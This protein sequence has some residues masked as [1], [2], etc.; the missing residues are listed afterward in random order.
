MGQPESANAVG[1]GLEVE[2]LSN[3]LDHQRL[4][5]PDS[6]FID[7]LLAM[8]RLTGKMIGVATAD[9]GMALMARINGLDV[10]QL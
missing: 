7:R 8:Q 10:V 2:F 9:T 6:E 5:D 4:H 1:P 3:P